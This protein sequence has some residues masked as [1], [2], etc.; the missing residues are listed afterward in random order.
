MRFEQPLIEGTLVR[1]QS[2]FLMEV[3]L[4]TGE[5][6]V[7]HCANP[8]SM[9]GCSEPGSRV[10]LSSHEDPRRRFKHQL[11]I[12]Y[13]GRVPIGVHTGRASSIVAEALMA[14]KIPE[15][16]GYATMRKEPR[17][18]RG[19]HIDIVLEGNGLR[20]CYIQA[21]NVTLAYDNIAYYPDIVFPEGIKHLQTLTNLVREGHRGM[22][23]LVAQRTD[24][25]S[26][27]PADHI[28]TE[29][30]QAFRDAVARGVE[31]L[32]YRAKVARKG[33]EFDKK[34]PLDLAG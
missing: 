31:V 27:R 1:R 17:Q 9:I 19:S 26:V 23:I 21:E 28:D 5:E 8:G 13:S 24:V 29:Y 32:C 33:I 7:A 15:V 34:L 3:K 18:A 10:L 6:I 11:E 4:R 12:I 20:P 2:K 14:S 16:A 22:F 25:E 30:S